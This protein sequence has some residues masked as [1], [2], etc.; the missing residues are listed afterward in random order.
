MTA[1]ALKCM[2]GARSITSI[3]VVCVTCICMLGAARLNRLPLEWTDISAW[4]FYLVYQR[5]G[6]TK[7]GC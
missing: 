7:S 3:H 2:L 5:A 4:N 6:V 1:L